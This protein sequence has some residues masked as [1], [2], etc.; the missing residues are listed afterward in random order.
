M[1]VA[2]KL[3]RRAVDRNRLRRILREVFRHRQHDLG[4]FDIVVRLKRNAAEDELKEE[5]GRLLLACRSCAK[6]PIT[7]TP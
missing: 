3:L 7:S 4:A 6:H 5:F 2:R 1:V